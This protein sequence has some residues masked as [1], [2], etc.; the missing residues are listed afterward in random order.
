MSTALKIFFVG[1]VSSGKSSLLNAI[2]GGIISNASIQRETIYPEVYPF[3]SNKEMKA[4]PSLKKAVTLLEKK[5]RANKS[6]SAAST[7]LIDKIDKPQVTTDAEGKHYIF[8]SQFGMGD[9]RI[10]D[11]PGL[12]DAADA[13]D[14]FFNLVSDNI[15]ECDCLVYITKAESAFISQSEVNLF[16]KLQALCEKRRLESGQFIKLCV[17]VNK[18]DDPYNLDLVQIANEIPS[19][20]A[21]SQTS[22][23]VTPIFRLSSHK[24]LIQNI[25]KH[26][27]GVPV[28]K[29]CNQEIQKIFQNAN[30]ITTKE[31]K[32][33]IREH[34][35]ISYHYIEFNEDIDNSDS[36]DNSSNRKLNST[37]GKKKEVVID[38]T[39]DSDSGSDFEDRDHQENADEKPVYEYKYEGDWNC[40]ID[41]IKEINGEIPFYKINTR[42]E[43]IKKCFSDIA[44]A[45]FNQIEIAKQKLELLHKVYSTFQRENEMK[46]FIDEL[47]LFITNNFNNELLIATIMFDLFTDA[48]R[49]TNEQQH[50]IGRTIDNMINNSVIETT[51]WKL[52]YVVLIVE[53]MKNFNYNSYD[54]I[55]KMIQNEIIWIPNNEGGK[56]TQVKYYSLKDHQYLARNNQLHDRFKTLH[57]RYLY[58]LLS[59]VTSN[60]I[61]K[62]ILLLVKLCF[63]DMKYLRILDLYNKIPYYIIE[64]YLGRKASIRFKLYIHNNYSYC[65]CIPLLFN[66]CPK[67]EINIEV[68]AYLDIEKQM[69]V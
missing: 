49:F 66:S 35:K 42:K 58:E 11:F 20:I 43:W 55:L 25:V 48:F 40:F 29:F 56:Y 47:V 46:N 45:N 9:F 28:P 51:N 17:V 10:V 5:H 64:Q 30:V 24:L 3:V 44:A 22:S 53:L 14:S 23:E 59:A 15:A 57:I 33:S 68:D 4:Y 31:Q 21:D 7:N 65:G 6:F 34:G 62:N 18:F 39:A 27:L 1:E 63:I 36:D 41:F 37:T 16:K 38:E 2:A 60:M 13:N 8:K 50:R 12:N 69:G 19:K 32:K 67:E 26:K 61:G 54:L 52:L